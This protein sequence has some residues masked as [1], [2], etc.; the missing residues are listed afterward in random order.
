MQPPSTALETFSA[1]ITAR[2]YGGVDA[3]IL[4]HVYLEKVRALEVS[5]VWHR[6]PQVGE[7]FLD[8]GSLHANLRSE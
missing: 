8:C 2:G 6:L 7:W 5:P 1:S 3:G 4:A